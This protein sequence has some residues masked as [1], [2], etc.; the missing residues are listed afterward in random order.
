MEFKEKFEV[1]VRCPICGEYH[2]I[3]VERSDFYTWARGKHPQDV[4][5][6]LSADEREIL[7]SGICPS[8]WDKEFKEAI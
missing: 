3:F 6:Y 7:I 5:P 1:S 2:S 8:C 4:F